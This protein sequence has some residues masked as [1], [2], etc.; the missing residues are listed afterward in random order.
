MFK[1]KASF[2]LIRHSNLNSLNA[3]FLIYVCT[4][5]AGPEYFVD[6]NRHMFSYSCDS[7]EWHVTWLQLN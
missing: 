5:K 3:Y 7:A 6:L 1:V 2:S 4:Y